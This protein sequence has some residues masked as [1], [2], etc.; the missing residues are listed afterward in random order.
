MKYEIKTTNFA[1][2]NA[3]AVFCDDNTIYDIINQEPV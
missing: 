2:F 3:K 1:N